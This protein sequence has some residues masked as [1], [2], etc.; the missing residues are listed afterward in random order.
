MFLYNNYKGLFL[1]FILFIFGLYLLGI[2]CPCDDKVRRYCRRLEI[3]GGLYSHIVFFMILG[4]LFPD[5]F[6][7]LMV[8]GVIYEIFQ[9]LVD[10]KLSDY[11]IKNNF[12]CLSLPPEKVIQKPYYNEK[13]R[14]DNIQNNSD[15][16][17]WKGNLPDAITNVIGFGI[18]YYLNKM[19]L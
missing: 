18:G 14:K 2:S 13:Y 3:Y 19:I 11:I 4:F 7:F 8:S 9:Y 5:N 12:G 6:I 16:H 17:I 15:L 10:I 1:I